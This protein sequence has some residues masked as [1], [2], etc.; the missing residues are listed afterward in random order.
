MN[1]SAEVEQA[2]RQLALDA[3]ER[4]DKAA[5]EAEHL[6]TA[7]HLYLA[8]F[9]RSVIANTAS[10]VESVADTSLVEQ[11]K[12]ATFRGMV[13]AW[14]DSHDGRII[15]RDLVSAAV[16]T[17]RFD[18][19]IKAHRTMWSAISQAAKKGEIER[20]EEG[21]YQARPV[22]WTPEQREEK[23]SEAKTVRQAL[24]LPDP[25]ASSPILYNE[26]NMP[27]TRTSVA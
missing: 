13:R 3:Q 12:N 6:A 11:L 9:D 7:L 15:V 19:R 26:P 5:Q 16:K 21:V 24:N 23:R 18:S 27:P 8:K 14:S 1:Y 17:G 2:L 4:A 25:D 22:T 20:L 10:H